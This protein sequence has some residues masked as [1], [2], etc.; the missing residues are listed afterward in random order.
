ML[1][2]NMTPEMAGALAEIQR[3]IYSLADAL[4]RVVEIASGQVLLNTTTEIRF[5]SGKLEIIDGGRTFTLEQFNEHLEALER[6]SRDGRDEPPTPS[7]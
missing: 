7:T 4:S 6:Y 2:A 5:G 3:K 1:S